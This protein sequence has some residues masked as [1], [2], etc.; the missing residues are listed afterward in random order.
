MADAVLLLA[1]GGPDSLADIPV[2]LSD[3]RGGRT[4]PDALLSEMT[5]RYE[6][7]GGRSP[8]LDITNQVAVKLAAATGLPVYVG[9]RH[10]HPRIADAV[11]QMAADGVRSV[12]AI[13]MAPHASRLSTGAYRA[14]LDEA[15]AEVGG[16]LKVDFVESWHLEPAYLTGL[17]DNIRATAA[18][19]PAGE[20][21]VEPMLVFTAHSLPA[22]ILAQGDPYDRQLAETAKGVA[23]LLGWA[24]D[25]W[26]RCYQSA[27]QTGTAW[28]GPAIEDAV[29]ELA[30]SGERNI[31]VAPTGFIADNV[32]ILYD[33]DIGLQT[34]ARSCGARVERIPMLND[35]PLLI[36]A[37]TDIVAR[38]QVYP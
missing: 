37:L 9:M 24:D 1:Y 4:T 8:L 10:W 28:L 22:T 15:V 5:H 30:E 3:V 25:R 13:C 7:I 27:A 38:L 34:I 6:L 18:R 36:Q 35:S 29:P 26:I 32:E 14:R 19:F 33:L 12:I 11:R 31:L 21:P 2:Y 16:E 20:R 23:G 17:A